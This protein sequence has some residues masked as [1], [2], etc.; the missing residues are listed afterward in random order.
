M[1]VEVHGIELFGRHGV[2][3]EER[4]DGQA[5]LVDVTV[6]V[7][8]PARDALEATLDYRRVREVVRAVNER[9]SFLLLETFAVAVADAL[10]EELRVQHV[11]V[12]VRKPGVDWAEWTAASV[13]RP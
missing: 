6:R 8:E 13:E 12:R 5:F 9:E 3:E 10:V 2:H 11:A 1:N 4:R 7:P